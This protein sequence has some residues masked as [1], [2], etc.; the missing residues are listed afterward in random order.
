M[1]TLKQQVMI[2]QFVYVTG[3]RT[4]QANQYLTSVNWHFEMAL[5]LFFQET[6]VPCSQAANNAS[7]HFQT[8]TNTPV[9]PPSFPDTLTSFSKLLNSSDKA[10]TS[11]QQSTSSSTSSSSQNVFTLQSPQLTTATNQQ[12]ATAAGEWGCN[13]MY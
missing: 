1:D 2:N 3:C 11:S 10:K 12:Q 9:T 8:P 6:A 5:S 4:D 13:A 7:C